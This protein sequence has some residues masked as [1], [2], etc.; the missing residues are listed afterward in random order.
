MKKKK[1]GGSKLSATAARKSSNTV[2]LQVKREIFHTTTEQ[3]VDKWRDVRLGN[4]SVMKSAVWTDE[5]AW[6]DLLE[7]VKLLISNPPGIPVLL[8][9]EMFNGGIVIGFTPD[10]EKCRVLPG[11]DI[12]LLRSRHGAGMDL[13]LATAAKYQQGFSLE[14]GG[15]SRQSGARLVVVAAR[16]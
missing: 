6:T 15:G 8:G 2:N 4:L 7:H 13:A 11:G 5:L 10:W 14:S 1:S 16:L 9:F 3:L 12:V